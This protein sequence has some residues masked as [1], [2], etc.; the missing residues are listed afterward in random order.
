MEGPV[1]S[2]FWSI[3][4]SGLYCVRRLVNVHEQGGCQAAAVLSTVHQP[5]IRGSQDARIPPHDE[6]TSGASSI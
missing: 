3:L 2:C 4:S 1:K 6:G 5:D